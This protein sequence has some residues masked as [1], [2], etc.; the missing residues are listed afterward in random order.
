LRQGSGSAPCFGAA[1]TEERLLVARRNWT[2]LRNRLE[3]AF[4]S[5]TVEI[6]ESAAGQRLVVPLPAAAREL[7]DWMH[8][9]LDR[10]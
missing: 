6:R 8:R 3:Q 4:G 2:D 5:P 9:D 10:K 1:G 7:L